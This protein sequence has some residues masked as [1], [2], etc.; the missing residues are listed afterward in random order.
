MES[1][2]FN[3]WKKLSLYT[4]TIEEDP[5]LTSQISPGQIPKET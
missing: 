2:N 3:K 1:T 4:I 5:N